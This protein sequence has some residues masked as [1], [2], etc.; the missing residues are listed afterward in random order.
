MGPGRSWWH[1]ASQADA[2]PLLRRLKR[3]KRQY[4]DIRYVS[5]T[6]GLRPTFQ[7]QLINATAAQ[8]RKKSIAIGGSASKLVMA[9]AH[10]R[11]VGPQ[12]RRCNGP[13]RPPRGYT[14]GYE[15]YSRTADG[16]ELKG[17]M[18]N[19][20]VITGISSN[21]RVP[22]SRRERGCSSVP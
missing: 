18:T 8:M 10:P 15:I 7:P 12:F 6:H 20:E 1:C 17:S 5:P 14:H 16:Q 11:S 3:G 21:L 9:T 2:F 19:T 4:Y 13:P 22:G